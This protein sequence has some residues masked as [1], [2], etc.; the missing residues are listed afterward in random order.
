M[1]SSFWNFYFHDSEWTRRQDIDRALETETADVERLHRLLADARAQLHDLSLTVA[2]LIKMLSEQGH[3]DP[4]VL[5][6]RVEAELEAMQ[7]ATPQDA[8]VKCERCGARV[9][10]SRTTITANGT[11]CDTCAA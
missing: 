3:V 8:L 11:Y 5:Q 4:H 1:G 6:L 9:P 2:V 7:P 10:S